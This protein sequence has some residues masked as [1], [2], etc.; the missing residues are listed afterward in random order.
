MEK[1]ISLIVGL[2]IFI[3]VWAFW[4][5]LLGTAFQVHLQEAVH[6]WVQFQLQA[7]PIIN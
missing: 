3:L 5:W 2:T 1:W 7:L 4:L 6:H